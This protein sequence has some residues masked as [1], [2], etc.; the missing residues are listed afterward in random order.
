MAKW[1]D[2][3]RPRP[4]FNPELVE[5]Y[6]RELALDLKISQRTDAEVEAV[7]T[8]LSGYCLRLARQLDPAPRSPTSAGRCAGRSPGRPPRLARSQRGG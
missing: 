6:L 5:A 7:F 4:P 1:R 2:G 8:H 3:E